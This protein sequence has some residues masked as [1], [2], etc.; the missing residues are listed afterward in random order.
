MKLA[1][2]VAKVIRV[3]ALQ[4]GVSVEFA[5]LPHHYEPTEKEVERIS[6]KRISNEEIAWAIKRL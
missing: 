1:K 5:T 6:V 4:Y 3:G 2:K